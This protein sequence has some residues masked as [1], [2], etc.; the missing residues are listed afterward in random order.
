VVSVKLSAA[1]QLVLAMGEAEARQLDAGAI[2]VEHLL[3]AF[4]KVGDQESR[5]SGV[6]EADWEKAR[7]E[8][9]RLAA[10]WQGSRLNPLQMRRRL[11]YLVAQAQPGTGSGGFQGARSPR[12]DQALHRAE[13]LANGDEIDVVALLGACLEQE[14]VPADQVF[15][16]FAADK[17][18]LVRALS[19]KPMGPVTEPT[20][21]ASM[22]APVEESRL[23]KYGRDLTALARAGR[24]T[25]VIG[26]REEMKDLA[27]I[28]SQA[29]RNNAM[30]VGEAGV[31]KTAV[32]EGLAQY[33][34]QPD[35]HPSVRDYHF[36]E[37]TLASLIAGPGGGAGAAA[38]LQEALQSAEGDP[39]LVLFF[40]EF[41]ALA[42]AADL[43]KPALAKGQ[44]HCIGATTIDEYQKHIERDPALARR[45]QRVWVGEPSRDETVQILR[46]LRDKLQEHHG[47]SIADETI[48]AAVDFTIRH[49]PDG[50][51]PDK[52][53]ILLDQACAQARIMTFSPD[54]APA[55][56]ELAVEAVAE[57]VAKRARLPVTRILMSRHGEI[58]RLSTSVD[59]VKEQLASRVI[60]QDL[61]VTTLAQALL[62]IDTGLEQ[63]GRPF[64]IMFAG[65]S[66]TGKTELA[67][68]LSKV[69]FGD[70]DRLI[71]LDMTRFGEEHHREELVGS[72]PGYVDSDKVPAWVTA[73]EKQPNSVV[74]LDEV[75]KAHRKVLEVFI[76]VFDEGR[77]VTA[78]NKVADF[79]HAI[80]VLT[81]NLG[82]GH[83]AG[84]VG[85]DV[86]DLLPDEERQARDAKQFEYEVR[87]AIS[88]SIRP[89]IL[90]RMAGIVVFQTLSRESLDRILD[91]ELAKVNRRRGLA[92]P[93]IEI[94]LDPSAR[95][96]LVE[97]GQSA[98]FGARHL[99]RQVERWVVDMLAPHMAEF[100]PGDRIV[101]RREGDAIGFE[102]K[103]RVPALAG[104]AGGS[105]PAQGG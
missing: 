8:L 62:R 9:G 92:Q 85:P 91:L 6:S 46:G 61:A 16:E 69:M 86:G 34:I 15:A 103:G 31:G 17:Q 77:L 24:L 105:G 25:P 59:A 102:V 90:N 65:P 35:A 28:L 104:S 39:H 23:A 27:R 74:V 37:I 96:F 30:L 63:E 99:S 12:Y 75:E 41:H 2:D 3:I 56:T 57:V 38:H 87:Q 97:Q 1:A 11:R 53:I 94:E 70:S 43:L 49:V 101:C 54:T 95:D 73:I 47:L 42:Q 36:V 82:T 67:K 5:P 14:S 88:N 33:A 58:T 13:E 84:R 80:F 64:V 45:F 21:P 55:P 81:S 79:S 52:A 100:S 48:E 10:L 32:V 44:V 76:P 50:H 98:E 51:L 66:G 60:G 20:S 26:R 22:P 18:A 19:A 29:L 72:P 7:R 68:A 71:T 89:E 40:D 78:M 4:L 93:G 83:K